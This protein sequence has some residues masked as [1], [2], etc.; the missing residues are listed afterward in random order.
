MSLGGEEVDL[1]SFWD[2]ALEASE[3]R[4]ENV[5]GLSLDEAR[6]QGLIPGDFDQSGKS[7]DPS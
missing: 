5:S 3:K 7:N 1:D 6:K 2:D 4:A